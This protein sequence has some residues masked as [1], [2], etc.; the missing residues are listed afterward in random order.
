VTLSFNDNSSA[1][2]PTDIR[3]ADIDFEDGTD[4][5]TAIGNYVQSG[6]RIGN[7]Q[8]VLYNLNCGV[9]RSVTCLTM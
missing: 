8:I 2:V 7:S 9:L 6:G 4:S 5:I 3:V 1:T